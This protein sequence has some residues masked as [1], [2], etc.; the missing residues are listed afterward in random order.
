MTNNGM[1][2]DTSQYSSATFYFEVVMSIANG[3]GTA[4]A[5]LRNITDGATVTSSEITTSSTTLVRVRSAAITMDTS[6]VDVYQARIKSSGT[7]SNTI[8]MANVVVIQ[9]GETI[10]KTERVWSSFGAQNTSLNLAYAEVGQYR[11]RFYVGDI[12]GTITA[13][14]VYLFQGTSHASIEVFQKLYNFT[15]G[16]EVTGSEASSTSTTAV[17]VTA[18]PTLVINKAYGTLIRTTGDSGFASAYGSLRIYIRQQDWTKTEAVIDSGSF[19]VQTTST[20][21]ASDTNFNSIVYLSTDF[22]DVTTSAYTHFCLYKPSANTATIESRL[23]DADGAAEVVLTSHAFGSGSNETVDNIETHSL[24]TSGNRLTLEQRRVTGTTGVT[25]ANM[26]F[27]VMIE[28]PAGGTETADVSP[29]IADFTV[30]AVT[31]TYEEIDTAAVAPVVTDV[32]IPAVTATYQTSVDGWYNNSCAWQYRVKVTVPAANVS[33]SQTD[34]P[35]YVDLS[36]LPA[37]FHTNVKAGGVDIRVTTSDGE[38]E[39]PREVVFYDADTDTG[40]LHFKGNIDDTVDTDFYIYYG[41]ASADDYARDD[42][43]G[44]ENVW[45]SNYLAVYHLQE[46]VNTDAGGYKD[47]T[48]N[49]NHGTGVSM[50]I[51]APAGKLT[52]KAAEFDG[53]AD[54]I[55]LPKLLTNNT[56]SISAWIFLQTKNGSNGTPIWYQGSG[57]A[58]LGSEFGLIDTYPTAGDET[59]FARSGGATLA[60][61]NDLNWT[62][63]E[64]YHMAASFNNTAVTFYKDG[65]SAGSGS[66]SGGTHSDNASALAAWYD[67]TAGAR[68]L[69]GL[70]DEV[71]IRDDVFTADFVA[72]ENANLDD[73]GAFYSIGTEEE[74]SAESIQEAEV[75]PVVASVTMPTVAATYIAVITASVA[76]VLGS[77]VVPAV[78]ATYDQ[79]NSASVA[80]VVAEFSVAEVEAEYPFTVGTD[81]WVFEL[82]DGVEATVSPIQILVTI[83]AVASTYIQV[84]TASVDTIPI[85]VDVPAVAATYDEVDA[86][87][88]VPVS[89]LTTI[90]EVTATYEEVDSAIVSPVAANVSISEVTATYIY[91]ASADVDPVVMEITVTENAA[92]YIEV[93]T[94]ATSPVVASITIVEVTATYDEVNSATVA[95]V[96]INAVIPDVT[97]T[98]IEIDIAEVSPVIVSITITET[99]ATY[100][101]INNAAVE[102]IVIDF[103]IPNVTPNEYYTAAVIPIVAEISI[104][105]VS[106]TYD[107]LNTAS[108]SPVLISVTISSVAADSSEVR[109]AVV[110][111]ISVLFTITE[112]TA[113]Y[114]ISDRAGVKFAI[115]PSVNRDVMKT[116]ESKTSISQSNLSRTVFTNTANKT[117]LKTKNI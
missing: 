44:L 105:S 35:V 1:K 53:A 19:N 81:Q 14:L 51:T 7:H 59:L 106:A 48:A 74:C 11:H 43:Y 4:Y 62:T 5:E 79:V 78:A 101:Q 63:D 107:Q 109:Q 38:T 54:R 70:L 33:A 67:Y 85:N 60:T 112:S 27:T 20:S 3:A 13:S 82:D 91:V 36:D 84:E 115:R 97:A 42:T 6:N 102:P 86:A 56:W 17:E 25:T 104:Q 9:E 55:S 66:V 57:S 68:Y 10:S 116:G 32:T 96:A 83:P 73:P 21:F 90:A 61:A 75:A 100:D 76:A 28:A 40:E 99:T 15:D 46:S 113:T 47:S 16:A 93:Q 65:A 88:V 72:I 95:P 69:D 77:F 26:N 64:W 58:D 34:F 49:E 103:S 22:V 2:I 45:N 52:G 92:T 111:A 94:A 39:V 30:P 87:A 31:A 18:T 24:P 23:Y 89:L 110:D 8:K 114:I 71:R 98:Y 29:V 12:D 117:I 108:V 50:A 37:G 41:N 80:P